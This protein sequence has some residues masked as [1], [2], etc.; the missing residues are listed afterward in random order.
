MLVPADNLISRDFCE[1]CCFIL[2]LS[3]RNSDK[4]LQLQSCL[5]YAESISEV[6]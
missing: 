3:Y 1:S 6:R 5:G 2:S 4:L